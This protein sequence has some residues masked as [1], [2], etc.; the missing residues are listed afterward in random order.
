MSTSSGLQASRA[1]QASQAAQSVTAREDWAPSEE[2]SQAS[3]ASQAAHGTLA[4]QGQLQTV[5]FG[6]QILS[7]VPDNA[8]DN[9]WS[10]SDSPK[11]MFMGD[12]AEHL[13]QHFT[14]MNTSKDPSWLFVGVRWH[15]TPPNREANWQHTKPAPAGVFSSEIVDLAKKYDG[16]MSQHKCFFCADASVTDW[17]ALAMASLLKLCR[18]V[19]QDKFPY[20]P[21]WVWLCAQ[22]H[23]GTVTKVELCKCMSEALGHVENF[24][25]QLGYMGSDED[26]FVWNLMEGSS[27]EEQ[28]KVLLERY[29]M[30][31][32]D[33]GGG[34]RLY[35]LDREMPTERLVEFTAKELPLCDKIWFDSKCVRS[36]R[37]SEIHHGFYKN[38][39]DGK[40]KLARAR[41]LDGSVWVSSGENM[42]LIIDAAIPHPLCKKQPERA[43]L[44]NASVKAFQIPISVGSTD[45]LTVQGQFET[46]QLGPEGNAFKIGDYTLVSFLSCELAGGAAS[47]T[48]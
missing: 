1:S 33:S 22:R 27:P 37:A 45:G 6:N 19:Q 48:S 9:G 35:Y 36:S 23:A 4:Q 2:A 14:A 8:I 41:K 12:N 31:R 16:I 38:M 18:M 3:Q 5:S 21:V 39:G 24:L 11:A 15:G 26:G 25:T 32:T 28:N 40:V 34:W 47:S 42:V 30:P 46:W 20:L 13:L 29:G 10:H 44:A 7:I 17:T 43:V